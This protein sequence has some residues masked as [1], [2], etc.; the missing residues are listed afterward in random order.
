MTQPDSSNPEK[1]EHTARFRAIMDA[2]GEEP[3]PKPASR[4]V[5]DR[6]PARPKKATAAP[7]PT[8]ASRRADALPAAETSGESDSG[9][10]SGKRRFGPAF[11]TV[12]GMLSLIVNAVLIAIV[13]ILYGQLS[14]MDLQLKQLLTLKS[15]PLETVKGLY[16]NFVAM[17]NAHIVAEIPVSLVVPVQFDL[18]INQQLDVILSQETSI[19][20]ARVTLSTGTLSIDNA[21]ADIKLPAGTRLPITLALTVPVDR[22]VPVSLVVPV[23]IDLANTDLHAPF[24]GLQDVIEP[25]Y[26][27]LDPQA[28]TPRG[29]LV[30]DEVEQDRIPPTP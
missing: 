27:L 2:R 15:L 24:A 21:L 8:P 23:D 16:D 6:L 26:C 25:L 3:Q 22:K 7:G 4:S 20:G 9:Q 11:W 1:D 17:D 18:Q 29:T 10:T 12:T 28:L 5:L 14:K 30:C 19:S 13:L